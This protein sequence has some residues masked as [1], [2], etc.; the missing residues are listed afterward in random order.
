MKKNELQMNIK[1][2][3]SKKGNWNLV[4]VNCR[5]EAC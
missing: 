1:K 2:Q 4:F 5:S 3:I